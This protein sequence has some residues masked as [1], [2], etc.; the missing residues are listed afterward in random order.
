MQNAFSL[1]LEIRQIFDGAL[2]FGELLPNHV[3]IGLA[4]GPAMDRDPDSQAG[5][6]TTK[7]PAC[8]G[9]ALPDIGP[10]RDS[11]DTDT[12]ANALDH[13]DL[14]TLG[15]ES[16]HGAA[17][18][19]PLLPALRG[20]RGVQGSAELGLHALKA[21]LFVQVGLHCAGEPTALH[22]ICARVSH[23]AA[24]ACRHATSSKRESS[25]A[26]GRNDSHTDGGHREACSHCPRRV[27]SIPLLRQLLI[28]LLQHLPRLLPNLAQCSR[29]RAEPQ[30]RSLNL[31]H[32]SLCGASTRATGRRVS[33]LE[34]ARVWDVFL[35][36]EAGPELPLLRLPVIQSIPCFADISALQ[37]AAS[38]LE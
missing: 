27:H 14:G 30:H 4:R 34:G 16:K 22:A 10:T 21:Q 31:Q 32:R 17:R 15:A 7:N 37:H 3:L 1:L 13:Q 8:D 18:R 25:D 5:T 29:R 26:A 9:N 20:S 28:L 24:D 33:R 12:E 2:H 11:A 35:G 36:S 19:Q 23:Q 38:N 6:N